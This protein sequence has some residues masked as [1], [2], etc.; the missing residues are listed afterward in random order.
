MGTIGT[1]GD[2]GRH[3]GYYLWASCAADAGCTH[4][5]DL[6]LGLLIDR[7]GEGFDFVAR[8]SELVGR[9][10]CRCCGR[11]AAEIRLGVRGALLH[12]D[13]G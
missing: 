2:L 8:R 3:P 13:A 10:V 11:R 6:D 4:F 12:G 7:F 9:L 1:L 5:A